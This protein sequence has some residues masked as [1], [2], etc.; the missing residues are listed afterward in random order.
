MFSWRVAASW[1]SWDAHAQRTWRNW[2]LSPCA[3]SLRKDAGTTHSETTPLFT[4]QPFCKPLLIQAQPVCNPQHSAGLISV[5]SNHP[6]VY[7]FSPCIEF[8]D[9]ASVGVIFNVGELLVPLAGPQ[10]ST[11][12]C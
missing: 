12:P 5:V 7:L 8:A 4:R 11:D 1:P 3:A 6:V 2:H 9:E 10:K